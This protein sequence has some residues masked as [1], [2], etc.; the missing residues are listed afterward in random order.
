MHRGKGVLPEG[1]ATCL[2]CRRRLRELRRLKPKPPKPPRSPRPARGN[3]SAR[4][5]GTYHQ[6]LRRYLI[7]IF[8]PG[9][10]C[11]RCG[12]PILA[13]EP[14]DL[15]HTDDRSGYLGLSHAWCNRGALDGP[16][17]RVTSCPVCGAYVARSG[18]KTCSRACG[19][20][21]RRRAAWPVNVT[22]AAARMTRSVL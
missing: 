2:P 8:E 10:P 13:G 7:S 22:F 21:L 20:E 6:R 9:Q 19:W 1:L 17:P 4:G 16:R 11:P 3:T 18:R 15:D 5:Y 12:G 14:V